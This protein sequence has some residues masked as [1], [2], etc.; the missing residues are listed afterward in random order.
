MTEQDDSV[1]VETLVSHRT[2]E[3][4]VQIAWYDHT[5]QLTPAQA[6]Q[7]ALQ[8]MEAAAITEADAFLIHFMKNTVG[9][10]ERAASILLQEFRRFREAQETE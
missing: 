8:L 6:R 5:G 7:L 3:P 2:G 4:L 9:T 10:D 1:W